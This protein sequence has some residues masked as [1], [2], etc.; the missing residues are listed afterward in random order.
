MKAIKPRIFVNDAGVG[1]PERVN[2]GRFDLAA[3]DRFNTLLRER[4]AKLKITSF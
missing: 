1:R 2:G 4:V 3:N